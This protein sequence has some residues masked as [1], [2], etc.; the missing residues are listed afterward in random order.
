MPGAA[1]APS[2]ACLAEDTSPKC[3]R[4][5]AQV[6]SCPNHPD[7]LGVFA[8]WLRQKPCLRPN[9]S[10]STH[11]PIDHLQNVKTGLPI[12]IWGAP[13]GGRCK[14]I[15]GTSMKQLPTPDLVSSRSSQPRTVSL[16]ATLYAARRHPDEHV[17]PTS[18][19]LLCTQKLF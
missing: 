15:L 7:A 10:R 12:C 16:S 13:R 9:C 11:R 3:T 18:S 17:G 6:P 19:Q 8:H 14:N 4:C 2:N 1:D 5:K